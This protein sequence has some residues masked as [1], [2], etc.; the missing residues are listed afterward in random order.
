M[1]DLS[2]WLQALVSPDGS[3]GATIGFSKF[4]LLMS[5]S[6]LTGL[7]VSALYRVFYRARSSGSEIHRAFPLI[8]LSITGIFICIQFSLPLSLGLLG[9][10]SIVRFRTP[11]K[12]PEEI[13]FLMLVVAG[14]LC[15]ATF[16]L[17]FLGA[18]LLVTVLVLALVSLKGG[19]VF[20]AGRSDGIV[21]LTLSTEEFQKQGDA[22][23]RLLAEQFP[24]G[25]LD[26]VSEGPA[27]AIVSYSFPAL[28]RSVLP[29]HQARWREL[30]SSLRS[31]VYFTRRG[32]S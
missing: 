16:N 27:E 22:L 17:V 12:E 31:D 2:D 3:R 4:F 10:L 20:G 18:L 9:A 24:K 5:I 6:A 28:V 13:G 15:C 23:L 14:A 7:F 29:E 8:S 21:V 19:G 26:A 11:V 32:G 30:C 1:S 25:T